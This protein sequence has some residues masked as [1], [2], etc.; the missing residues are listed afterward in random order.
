MGKPTFHPE[1]E[2]EYVDALREYHTINPRVGIKFE[3]AIDWVLDMAL[4]NPLFFPE[5]DFGFRE[6]IL[7]R[8]PFS[9]IYRVEKSGDLTVMAVAHSSREPGYWH[10]RQ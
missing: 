10:G 2:G 4:A 1:A 9:I 6:A 5:H 7:T 3:K 8:F